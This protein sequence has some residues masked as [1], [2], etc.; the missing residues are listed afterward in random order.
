[1]ENMEFGEIDSPL[2]LLNVGVVEKGVC[3]LE[4]QHED[5]LEKTLKNLEGLYNVTNNRTFEHWTNL[6]QQLTAY[7]NKGLQSFSV[8]L[9]PMGTDF[10]KKVWQELLSIPYGQ[11]RSYKDQ[12]IAIG[13]LK[14]IRA[15]A[16]ANG[17]NKISILVPCHRVIGTDG[18]LTGYGGGLDKKRFLLDLESPQNSLF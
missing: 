12:A 10:Q 16:T 7:F 5:R 2:G 8:P 15:V 4:F 6:E 1:M 17:A 9:R 3:M 18:S 11:T 14:A 13:D